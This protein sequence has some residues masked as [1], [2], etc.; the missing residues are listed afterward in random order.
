MEEGEGRGGGVFVPQAPHHNRLDCVY[1]TLIDEYKV[2]FRGGGGASGMR[3]H[4]WTRL[5]TD[6][7]DR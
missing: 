2:F 1:H 3:E 5:H 7:V 6:L 4:A